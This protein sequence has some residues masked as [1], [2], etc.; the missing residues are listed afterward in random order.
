MVDKWGI[1]FVFFFGVF[2]ISSVSA[3]FN[4]GNPKH[5]LETF[6][7]PSDNVTGGVNISFSS[8]PLN[9]VFSDSSGNSA[10]LSEV[11]KNNAGYYYSCNPTDCKDDYSLS[12]PSQ[13]KTVTLNSVDSKIYAVKLTG[14]IFKIDS[15]KFIIDS[16]AA[17]S[18]TN[19]LE[20]DFL[21]DSFLDARNNNALNSAICSNKDYGCFD[22]G[23]TLEEP[24]I[25]GTP[26]CEKVNLSSSPGFSIGAWIKKVSGLSTIKASIYDI[27]GGDALASCTL[28][29][30]TSSGG[31]V[32]CNVNYSVAQPGKYYVCI[33][34]TSGT[35]NYTTKGYSIT[36]G[37]GF[38]GTPPR[39]LTN[40]AYQIFSKGNQFGPV[41]T[42][43]INKSMDGRDFAGMAEDYLIRKYGSLDCS[44]GCVIPIKI[45][46]NS[47]QVVTLRNLQVDYEKDIGT[48]TESNFYEVSKT[49]A[50]INS[51]FQQLYLDGSG[52][53]VP[54]N[55]GNFTFSLQLDGQNVLSQM[56][57]VKDVPIIKSVTPTKTASAYPTEFRVTVDSKYN[58]TGFSWNFG[59]NTSDITTS[60]NNAS[61]T[62]SSIGVYNLKVKVT[63]QRKLSSTKTFMINVSSPKDLINSTLND[64]E[65]DI[66]NLEREIYSFLPIYQDAINSSLNISYLKDRISL[67]KTLYQNATSEEEYN[68]I[69]TDLVGLKIPA[70][71]SKSRSAQDIVLLSGPSYVNLNALQEIG[72]GTYDT[73]KEQ[74]YI[75]AALLWQ[76]DNLDVNFNFNEF[77]GRYPGYIEPIVKV[78]EIKVNEKK[79]I[80]NDYYFI[81][82]EPEG[83]MTDAKFDRKSGYIYINLKGQKSFSFSTTGDVDFTNLPAFISPA[84]SELTIT[85]TLPEVKNTSKWVVFSVAVFALLVIA[86]VIYIIMQQWYKR[87]YENYLFKNRN[88]LY[89][90]INYVNNAKRKGLKNNQIEE[91]LKKVGWSSEKIR[92]V[93]RKY[94]GKRTG[95]FEIIP[96]KKLAEN[97]WEKSDHTKFNKPF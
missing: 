97:V 52:F 24:K 29:D 94:A 1:F 9:S 85:Q 76:Q 6:Y 39:S 50:K 51:T 72:G 11:L 89:N 81:L 71:I 91:N 22:S 43:Q 74:D 69:V 64:K 34:S 44:L 86:F 15:F 67:L 58:L 36:N 31:E 17:A 42:L 5:S 59:D 46:S 10:N 70:G 26:F 55:F 40:V 48:V 35:G 66:S 63:D 16:T 84:I 14:N 73:N 20:V 57:E 77:S 45:N 53:S 87:R 65:R 78:F 23:K 80:P 61:H 7:G 21:D 8:E 33:Q 41:G 28:P 90:M 49:P 75:N 47:N 3:S 56:M 32:S 27:S 13:T 95:M 2:L 37:C 30:A 19:Q 12:N 83:F 25:D 60:G 38:H 68:A 96:I 4:V 88:D 82:P 79:D 92:Y 62:Y 54:S 18:C 93:M